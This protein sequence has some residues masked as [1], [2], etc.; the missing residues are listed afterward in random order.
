MTNRSFIANPTVWLK[1][2]CP[3]CHRLTSCCSSCH[4]LTGEMNST[5]LTLREVRLI[6]FNFLLVKTNPNSFYKS[7]AGLDVCL[8]PKSK[9]KVASLSMMQ[10]FTQSTYH[11]LTVHTGT[12]QQHLGAS[13]P[14]SYSRLT[15][16][17]CFHR[18]LIVE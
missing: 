7:Y 17:S 10:S 6:Q 8:E 9:C 16:R 4:R 3:Y 5:Y 12:G 15:I 13:V 11:I 1:Q 14:K 2:G 18:A